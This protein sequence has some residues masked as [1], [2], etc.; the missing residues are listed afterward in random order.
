MWKRRL[1]TEKFKRA[2][3]NLVGLGRLELPTSP[4][5]GVR[6]SHLSY[7]PN[8]LAG[9]ILRE[10]ARSSNNGASCVS[11]AAGSEKSAHAR[12]MHA[13]RSLYLSICERSR[14]DRRQVKRRQ[15]YRSRK[16]PSGA[17]RAEIFD[18]RLRRGLIRHRSNGQKIVAKAQ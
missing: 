16:G 13:L 7:R 4:L 6:S 5:S 12:E 17:S 18:R 8:L 11:R 2:A 9:N 15:T 10:L 14:S 1:A 3:E